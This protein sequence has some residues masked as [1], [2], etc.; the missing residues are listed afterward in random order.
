MLRMRLA[1]LGLLL[2]M[3]CGTAPQAVDLT[4]RVRVTIPAD[5][6]AAGESIRAVIRNESSFPVYVASQCAPGI[7]TL[8]GDDWAS[9]H[10]ILL[11]TQDAPPPEKL[12]PGGSTVRFIITEMATREVLPPGTYRGLFHI[13]G[14]EW[15]FTTRYSPTFRLK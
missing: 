3:G 11:C 10:M 2:V 4:P 6:Y 5:E 1:V 8:A 12:A 13:S 7:E 9:V 14:S 15:A